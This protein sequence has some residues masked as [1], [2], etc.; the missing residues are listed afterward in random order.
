M[1]SLLDYEKKTDATLNDLGRCGMLLCGVAAV[2]ALSLSAYIAKHV[3][4]M[5][6]CEP[7][8]FQYKSKLQVDWLRYHY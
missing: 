1:A 3:T 8:R 6:K 5:I 2:L 7:R 4:G